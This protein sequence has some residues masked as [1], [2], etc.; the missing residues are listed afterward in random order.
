[1][2]FLITFYV[3]VSYSWIVMCLSHL[4]HIEL[5]D[6]SDHRDASMLSATSC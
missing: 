3:L 1:M 4:L 6:I 2:V 5:L